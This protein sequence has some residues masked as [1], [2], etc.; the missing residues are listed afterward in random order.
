MR[1][2]SWHK[3]IAAILLAAGCS[4]GGT[5]RLPI[6]EEKGTVKG[7][8]PLPAVEHL[9]AQQRE[10]GS[11]LG[12]RHPEV[13]ARHPSSVAVSALACM[14]LLDYSEVAP[15]RIR[16]PLEK[17]ITACLE[18]AKNAQGHW[19]YIWSQAYPL[20]LIAR[21]MEH[22][23]W[24][25]QRERWHEEGNSF[26]E[27]VFSQQHKGGGWGYAGAGTAFQTA[28]A[29]HALLDAQEAGLKVD[30]ERIERGLAFLEDFR[31]PGR[32]YYYVA[33]KEARA[34]WDRF[35]DEEARERT[36]GCVMLCEWVLYRYGKVSREALQDAM[37]RFI[38]HKS[39][40]WELRGY[41]GDGSIPKGRLLTATGSPYAHFAFYGYRGSALA[42]REMDGENGKRWKEILRDD[43]LEVREEDGTWLHLAK[44]YGGPDTRLGNSV[45]A[46]ASA[47]LVLKAL[48]G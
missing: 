16:P 45:Y 47:L 25:D 39:F 19:S 46:T 4:S 23:A 5:A 41:T 3:S 42:V 32:G 22:P 10:D 17:G 27:R 13:T 12:A 1:G 43:L 35:S 26:V 11:W 38:A 31:V 6:A 29:L 44:G 40:L 8:N 20:R 21:L 28:D 36:A 30:Q 15:E 7:W 37:E 24:K 9:I 2:K 33:S 18:N 48:E 14:A 34:A